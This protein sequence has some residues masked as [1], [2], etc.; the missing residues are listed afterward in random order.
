MKQVIINELNKLKEEKY[1][2][3]SSNLIPN[4]NNIL[5][6]RIP[7][8]R[9]I[10]K[11]LLKKDYISYLDE[12]EIYFEEIMI[13]SFVIA[14]LKDINQVLELTNSHI[15]K[16]DN[17]SLCDSFCSELK[18]FNNNKIVFDYLEKYYKSNKVYEIRFAVVSCIFY[19]INDEFIDKVLYILDNIKNENYYVKMSIAWAI[20]ICFIKYKDKTY[21]YLYN[22]NLEKFTYNKALQKIIES[23]QV[24]IEDKVIIKNMKIK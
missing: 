2:S 13:K 17:W 4:C 18:I 22:N 7:Y 24:S 23:K 12:K 1:K 6:V 10:A 14:N 9:K 21:N 11:S 20:S 15:K 8:L 3:F 16:I 5:G 19:F